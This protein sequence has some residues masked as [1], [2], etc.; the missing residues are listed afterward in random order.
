MKKNA[1]KTLTV[2]R[3]F[4]GLLSFLLV[5]FA[6]LLIWGAM[7]EVPMHIGLFVVGLL[8]LVLG[9]F[10]LAVAFFS[11]NYQ[12]QKVAN[13]AGGEAIVLLPIILA[14]TFIFECIQKKNGGR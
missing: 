1:N 10:C 13:S 4:L 6:L 5:G 8:M 2:D 14:A 9:V 12:V 11:T 7:K 3:V